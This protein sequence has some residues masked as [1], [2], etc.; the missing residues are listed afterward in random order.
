MPFGLLA[1]SI[2]PFELLA[3]SIIPFGQVNQM[4]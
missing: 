3:P 4:V 2:I 1:P